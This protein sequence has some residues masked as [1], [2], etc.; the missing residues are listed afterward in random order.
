M[1]IQNWIE[2]NYHM[3]IKIS[4][5]LAGAT[6]QTLTE[7]IIVHN[8][9]PA[10]VE[11]VG[12]PPTTAL[13]ATQTTT[14]HSQKLAIFPVS[15]FQEGVLMQTMYYG[16]TKSSFINTVSSK[17]ESTFSALILQRAVDVLV[18]RHKLFFAKFSFS[19]GQF[20][21]QLSPFIRMYCLFE[22]V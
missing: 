2:K 19:E 4:E 12:H 21:M 5:I 1:D 7:K 13:L 11:I 8:K 6:V 10:N 22:A 9:T 18:Q 14:P 16:S 15:P 20:Q 17:V 3:H